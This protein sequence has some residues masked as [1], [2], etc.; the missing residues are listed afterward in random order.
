MLSLATQALH[1]QSKYRSYYA[2]CTAQKPIRLL[3]LLPVLAACGLSLVTVAAVGS[4]GAVRRFC[5][6]QQLQDLYNDFNRHYK[7]TVLNQM[8]PPPRHDSAD[9]SFLE[10]SPVH[11]VWW[12][13]L[14]PAAY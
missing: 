14:A 5:S 12:G 4:P 10:L 8:V 3:V 11:L 2:L 7:S 6:V 13:P 9:Q 1:T